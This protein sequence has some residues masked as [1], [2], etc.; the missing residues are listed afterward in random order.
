MT[1]A[2][3]SAAA[4]GRLGAEPCA[5]QRNGC[6]LLADATG[7]A[8]LHRS[9]A[10]KT[11]VTYAAMVFRRKEPDEKPPMSRDGG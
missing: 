5:G 8:K 2:A 10:G 1:H 6:L 11:G 4:F 9:V 7:T 3:G